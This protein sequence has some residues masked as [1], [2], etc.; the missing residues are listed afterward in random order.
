M[1]RRHSYRDSKSQKGD[2]SM[3][4][5]LATTSGEEKLKKLQTLRDYTMMAM[6]A[7]SVMPAFAADDN[8]LSNLVAQLQNVFPMV[9]SLVLTIAVLILCV[10]GGFFIMSKNER[11]SEAAFDWGKK[12]LIGVAVVAA[13]P[14]LIGALIGLLG[15]GITGTKISEI[16]NKLD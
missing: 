14:W 4:Y 12:I 11:K 13:A 16:T 9:R 7:L 3:I 6:M 1:F 8:A 5:L 10:C 15:N 2:H